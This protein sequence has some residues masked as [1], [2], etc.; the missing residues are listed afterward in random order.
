MAVACAQII[1]WIEQ[2]AP[3]RLAEDWDAIGLQ[4][5]SPAAAI[6]GVYVALDLDQQVIDGALAAGCQLIVTH[7]PFLFKP[8][9]ALRWDQP[10]GALIRTLVAE[11][12]QVYAAHTNLDSATGGVNDVL[13]ETLGLQ[14]VRPLADDRAEEL[15]KIVVFVPLAQEAMVRKAMGD[16]GAGQLGDYSHCTF[17]TEGLGS[18]LPLPGAQPFIGQTGVMEEVQEC[19][20]EAIVRKSQLSRVLK[21][22]L[23]AHP[24]EEVAY[25]V[26]GLVNRG[27]A[28]GLGRYGWLAQSM[29][30]EDL[31]DLVKSR[32]S[33]PALRW[34]GRDRQRI[35]RKIA[36]CGG[37]GM[38]LLR[39]A[40][41]Q[42]ADLLLTGDVKYHEAQMALELGIDVL[43]A[44]HYATEQPVIAALCTYLT[45]CAGEAKV[46]L[47][48]VPHRQNQDPFTFW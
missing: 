27:P 45:R 16:A 3:K 20:V 25:D 4:V 39:P 44:G 33:I 31:V 41:M 22:M 37:S 35:V 26:Y 12:L 36:L 23:K 28:Q 29:T 13:A 14:E 1:Q 18:F 11:Q 30:V 32:L 10:Q 17:R 8:L 2:L 46:P 48:V 6:D 43:D 15:M 47:T 40:S 42:G 24:Y 34:I 21:A 9:K 5:G 19:R 38:S 7:H